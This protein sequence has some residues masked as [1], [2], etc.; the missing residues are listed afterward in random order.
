MYFPCSLAV[1]GPVI[2]LFPLYAKGTE[3][4]PIS[5]KRIFCKIKEKEKSN[6]FLANLSVMLLL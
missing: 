2:E 6:P 1:V 4:L 5:L 3:S